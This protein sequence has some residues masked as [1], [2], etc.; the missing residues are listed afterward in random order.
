MDFPLY[1]RQRMGLSQVFAK[2][3]A[4]REAQLIE[5]AAKHPAK[6]PPT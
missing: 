1:Q 6:L 4:W 5:Q 2:Q 3:A